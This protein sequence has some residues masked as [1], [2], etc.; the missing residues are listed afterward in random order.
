MR[1]KIEK[2]KF[3]ISQKF[4]LISKLALFGIFLSF[5]CCLIILQKQQSQKITLELENIASAGDKF[6]SSSFDN[7]SYKLSY[8]ARQIRESG[9]SNK[10]ISDLFV[11]ASSNISK[12]IEATVSWS[13]FSWIDK[14]DN[15]AV[16]GITGVIKNPLNISFRPYLQISK[17][18]LNQSF[19]AEPIYG[20]ITGL[21]QIPIAMGI[22]S[23]NNE[24]LGTLLFCYDV[25]KLDAEI[26]KITE[27][28]NI[29][30]ALIQNDKIITK[31]DNFDEASYL[32]ALAQDPK[33]SG[34]I[35]KQTIFTPKKRFIVTKNLSNYPISIAVSY[36]ENTSY[37]QFLDILGKQISIF[38]ALF[39]V[40]VLIIIIFYHRLIHPINKLS[41]FAS[42]ILQKNYSFNISKPKSIEF[43]KLYEAVSLIKDLE[44]NEQ[45]LLKKI[46]L[47]S[48]K[49]TA[50]NFDRLEF[51]TE[52]THDIR[53]P[54]NAAISFSHII[55]DESTQATNKEIKEWARDIENCITEILQ[56][57]NDL[58]EINQANL[59]E[60]SINLSNKID[61][62][63]IIKRSIR[64]NHHLVRDKKIKIQNHS[65]ANVSAINL[66]AKRMKQVLASLIE[67]AIKNSPNNSEIEIFAQ[68]NHASLQLTIKHR[69]IAILEEALDEDIEN[70]DPKLSL[71][72]RLIELQGGKIDFEF[73]KSSSTMIL[74]FPY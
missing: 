72:K 1:R 71:A 29:D 44:K 2:I 13:I 18:N 61:I 39:L 52:I 57:I 74:S 50:E 12:E 66:D 59:G 23:A 63:D 68:K 7:G 4:S 5:F 58:H 22:S 67:S 41:N 65:S 14:N 17:N 20:T 69:N 10:F 11:L 54:L 33:K 49:V 64:I 31:S 32:E 70:S 60:L 40:A 27:S 15:L 34:V 55:Q 62:G 51:L 3:S 73:N 26:L 46:E 25:K 19:V 38:F 30:F 21:Y 6:L 56:F 42:E 8:I 37:W 16:D 48:K 24:Y 36:N 53:N 45:N 28:K 47:L 9:A 35:S 43:L